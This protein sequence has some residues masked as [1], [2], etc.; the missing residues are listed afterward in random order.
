MEAFS[1]EAVTACN[2][3]PVTGDARLSR[4]GCAGKTLRSIYNVIPQSQLPPLS[5]FYLNNIK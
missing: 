5:F 2:N 1:F 4:Q 3:C